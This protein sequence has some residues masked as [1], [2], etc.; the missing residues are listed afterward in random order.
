M[1]TLQQVLGLLYGG[2]M[3]LSPCDGEKSLDTF[4]YH[5]KNINICA[6]PGK[7]NFQ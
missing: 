7:S 6:R 5:Y 4:F 2:G 1:T 3:C